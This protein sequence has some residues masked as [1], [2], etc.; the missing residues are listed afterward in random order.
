MSVEKQPEHKCNICS[1]YKPFYIKKETCFEKTR[2]GYC[3]KCEQIKDHFETC[4]CWNGKS[5]R[6]LSRK[7]T[8]ERVLKELM[9]HLMAIRKILQ[10]E[11]DE[12]NKKN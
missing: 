12:K 3:D 8:T 4:D 2:N 10:E 7:W 11:R 9:F 1:H 6:W 5:C